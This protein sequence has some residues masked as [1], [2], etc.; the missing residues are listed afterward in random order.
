MGTFLGHFLPGLAFA[1]LSVW[2]TVSSV[3]TYKLRGASGFRSTTWFPFPSPLRG[4]RRLELYLLL[5]SV[6]AI[7]DQLVDLP[8]LALWLQLDSLEHATMYLLA[9]YASVALAA[10][11]SGHR[12]GGVGDVVA[13]LAA[14]VFG[15]ELFLLRFHSADHAGLEGH[16]HWLLQLAVAA[17]LVATAASA[18]LP[19]SFAVA[20]VRSAS[21]LWVPALV[22]SGCHA[23]EQGSAA[24]RQGRRRACS[25][26]ARRERRAR[27]LFK[28]G[29]TSERTEREERGPSLSGGQLAVKPSED[30]TGV[31]RLALPNDVLLRILVL[32]EDAAAAG[33]TSVLATRWRRLWARLPELRFP[34]SPDPRAIAAALV[35]HEAALSCLDVGAEDA[36]PESV[37]AWLPVAARRLSGSLVFTNRVPGESANDAGEKTSAFDLPCFGNATSVTLDL[38]C[39]GVAVPR[40][41]V[42]ARLTEL[43]LSH[44][45]FRGPCA[46]GDAASSRRCPC[47]EK[48]TV[49]DTL[50]LNNLTIRSDSLRYLRL[51]SVRGLQQLT[52]VVPA[53]EYLSVLACFYHH[54]NRI[55]PSLTSQ[56][57]S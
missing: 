44:A 26:R 23:V 47:L 17:S 10:D 30:D 57:V 50:G 25:W 5:S 42:F 34:F 46:L 31:D 13:A 20:V 37:A 4:L 6:L 14:S 16:Y 18:V 51:D 53:M 8:I 1:I 27:F 3:R 21:A 54:Q 52:L 33:R 29:E 56:P 15:Q 55:D 43:S 11:A 9:V 19:R 45:Q 22:P 7:I 36:A 49:H 28:K 40:A 39:L 2:H 48:L 24:R 38:G 41:G 32:L 35:T 12:D